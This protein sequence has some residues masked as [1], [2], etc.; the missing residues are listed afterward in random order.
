[1]NAEQRERY[2]LVQRQ[3][4]AALF[5]EAALRRRLDTA[6]DLLNAF[7]VCVSSDPWQGG[8][9]DLS[10]EWAEVVPESQP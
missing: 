10:A 3:L 7:G 9:F 2:N 8:V 4:R 1:M 6:N 5:R